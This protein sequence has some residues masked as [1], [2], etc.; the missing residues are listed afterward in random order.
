[1]IEGFDDAGLLCAVN[2]TLGVGGG[3]GFL[4]EIGDEPYVITVAH[5]LPTLPSAHPGSYL[6]ERCF[7]SLLGPLG[8]EQTVWAEC[9]F[10]DPISDIAVLRCPDGQE[11]SEE[12]ERFE[13]LVDP[14]QPLPI[15]DIPDA[16]SR[17][18]VGVMDL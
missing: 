14:I 2:A 16:P 4:V 12:A 13:E 15:G 3:R 1:M 9:I 11:L 8:G 7:P 17:P 10:V 6:E 18:E 5:C